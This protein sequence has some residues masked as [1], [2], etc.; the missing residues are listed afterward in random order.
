LAGGGDHPARRPVAG[1]SPEG[2][3]GLPERGL[4]RVELVREPQRIGQ[5]SQGARF[6]IVRQA[7]RVGGCGQ[8]LGDLQGEPAGGDSARAVLPVGLGGGVEEASRERPGVVAR[9]PGD[10]LPA[11][12]L[13]RALERRCSAWMPGITADERAR[14]LARTWS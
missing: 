4:G 14:L 13:G 9:V 6:E 8:A 2:G 1:A 5:A 12:G 7:G 10:E 3:P 11:Q